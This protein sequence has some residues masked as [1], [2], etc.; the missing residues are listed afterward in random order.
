MW[1][2]STTQV[3]WR[4]IQC[5]CQW[6]FL[7]HSVIYRLA[8]AVLNATASVINKDIEKLPSQNTEEDHHEVGVHLDTEPLT[9][10][11]WV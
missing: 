6:F 11:L 7:P 2:L 1:K 4:E 8:G 9:A 3:C 5:W 10:T